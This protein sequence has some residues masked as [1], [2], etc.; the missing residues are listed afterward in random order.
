MTRPGVFSPVSHSVQAARSFSGSGGGGPADMSMGGRVATYA[1]DMTD[2]TELSTTNWKEVLFGRDSFFPVLFLAI[3]TILLSPMIDEFHFGFLI[4][5]PVSALMVLLAFHSSRVSKRTM[6]TV[7][8]L[9][10][11]VGVMSVITSIARIVDFTDDRYLIA[12]SAALFAV[13]I[14]CA[15]PVVVRRAFQHERVTLN[16]LAAGITAYLLIGI[17][18]SSLYRCDSALQHFQIFHETLHPNAGD[19]T[20]FSFITLT[21]VG[22][23][24]LTPATEFA[25]SLSIF[26][27]ILGQVF[28]VTAVARIVSL[29]GSQKPDTSRI[30]S[31]HDF[32]NHK[33][34]D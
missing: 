7:S 13:L 2:P 18:F 20:Y 12:V 11:I 3:L 29:L 25:R 24:D 4:V 14:A 1:P 30:P 6:T 28:L 34:A 15:F 33:D 10:V 9:L 32:S 16:T 26:E 23:G 27:A 19:Y 22:F 21:T 17:F 8:V 5:Y 31:G